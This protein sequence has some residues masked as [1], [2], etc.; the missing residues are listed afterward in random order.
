MNIKI[1]VDYDLCESNERC[2]A[3]SPALFRVNDAD[4]LE[5]LDED[6]PSA[7][8][9]ELR[10]AERVCPRGAITIVEE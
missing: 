2:V 1:V 3:A 4:Q 6:P 5:V 7:R 10:N 8:L 9:Q